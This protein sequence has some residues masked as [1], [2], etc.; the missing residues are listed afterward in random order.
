MKKLKIL[1][2]VVKID[3]VKKHIKPL[4]GYWKCF[5]IF[6]FQKAK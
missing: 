1:L 2:N 3:F 5:Q 4:R 6:K